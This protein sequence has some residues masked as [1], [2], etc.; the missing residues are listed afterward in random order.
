MI[1]KLRLRLRISNHA[2]RR[3]KQQ[4]AHKNEELDSNKLHEL[5]DEESIKN[6][7]KYTKIITV[8]DETYISYRAAFNDVNHIIEH[9]VE[10]M[11]K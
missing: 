3:S 11:K 2:P 7:T 1:I 10:V 5:L 9:A 6:L 4:K 8:N